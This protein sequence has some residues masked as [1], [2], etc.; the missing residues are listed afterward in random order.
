M[1]L[2]AADKLLREDSTRTS[3]PDNAVKIIVLFGGTNPS[4]YRYGERTVILG[5][6]CKEQRMLMPGIFKESYNPKSRDLFDHISAQQLP[7]L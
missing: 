5:R 1:H 6:G 7:C 4:L 3:A 2:A